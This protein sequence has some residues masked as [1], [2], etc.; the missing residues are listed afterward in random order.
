MK[1]WIFADLKRESMHH[2][3]IGKERKPRPQ[4]DDS[5]E[6]GYSKKIITPYCK[7]YPLIHFH[8]TPWCK[9]Y[10]LIWTEYLGNGFFVITRLILLHACRPHVR[11]LEWWPHNLFTDLVI[12]ARKFISLAWGSYRFRPLLRVMNLNSPVHFA[13]PKHCK[14]R[15]PELLNLRNEADKKEAGKVG[16]PSID[17]SIFPQSCMSEH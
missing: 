15:N 4:K 5:H 9:V 13:R 17:A 7:G 11:L 1:L 12:S 6:A 16:W 3:C 10:P 2:L 8:S 14:R